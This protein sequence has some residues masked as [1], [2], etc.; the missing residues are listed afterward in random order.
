[1]LSSPATLL[2]TRPDSTDPFIGLTATLADRLC[3]S[4]PLASAPTSRPATPPSYIDE[5]LHRLQVD[6]WTSVPISDGFAATAIST[7]LEVDHPFHAL[8]DANLFLD[9][10]INRNITFCSPFLVTSLLSHACVSGNS[11]FASLCVL[12][13]AN[14]PYDS[15][16]ALPSTCGCRLSVLRFLRKQKYSTRR[17]ACPVVFPTLPPSHFSA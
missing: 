10:L 1:M 13:V 16:P 12:M 17:S 14:H 5:R 8:F 15:T 6:Y 3:P 7:Y 11:Y 9:D 4:R 2:Q